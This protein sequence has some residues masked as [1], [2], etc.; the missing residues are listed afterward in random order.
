[1]EFGG[2]KETSVRDYL[3]VIFKYKAVII[4]SISIIMSLVLINSEMSSRQAYMAGVKMVISGIPNPDSELYTSSLRNPLLLMQVYSEVIRTNDVID[5]V[6]E[7]LRLDQ[8]P[9]DEELKYLSG[10]QAFLL[11]RKI[12]KLKLQLEEMNAEQ[13]KAF[14]FNM[15]EERLKASISTAY[16]EQ[17]PAVFTIYVRD[18]NPDAAVMM[19]NSLSRSFVI[20]N[21]YRQIEENKL[22]YGEKHSSVIQ[23]HSYIEEMEKT[24]DG[25]LLPDLEAL[26]PSNVKIIE[27]ARTADEVGSMPRSR[28]LIA[29][30]ASIFFGILLVFVLD[31]IDQTFKSPQDV[32]RFLNMPVIGSIPKRKSRNKLILS[33]N[34]PKMKKYTLSFQNLSEQVYF[35]MKDKKLKTLLI[36]DID[37]S[38]DA[39]VISAN[40][41]IYLSLKSGYNVLIIDANL[42][43]PSLAELF[44]IPD[45]P[46]LI[47]VIRDEI[48]FEA[49]VKHMGSNLYVLPTSKA[50]S[51]P[52][53]YLDSSKM[54]EVF[55]A[56][57]EVYDL[58]IFT[59]P[60]LKNYSDA[61]LL[62]SKTDGTA[63]II[64]EGKINRQVAKRLIFPLE[65]N[66]IKIMVAIFN[67]R[68]YV[69]PEII[70]KLT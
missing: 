29:F 5:R 12:N 11:A 55:N 31:F 21:M 60:D 44:K 1:M 54:L 51:N 67:N 70:Y 47:D 19:V 64:N 18:I 14:L 10:L 41:G 3:R 39:D 37:S 38:E 65:Q 7:T 33:E 40:L 28:Y 16:D 53:T 25:K 9:I 23:L 4:I 20:D 26:G 52:V 68:T 8:R 69:I 66:N 36:T 56:A 62:S 13:R 45:S 49:A 61:V 22:R 42:R 58:V 59:C 2:S 63:L 57:Q 24:L 43:H 27:Q 48:A 17:K 46:G 34:N 32:E 30:L 50:A 6:V 15:A 35:L